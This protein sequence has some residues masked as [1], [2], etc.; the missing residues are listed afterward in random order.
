M[1]ILLDL[2]ACQASSMHR[3]IG[4]YSMALALAMARNS[5]GHE[6]R[7]L[8]NEDYP[9]SVA[10]IRTA[11]D[12]LVP[13]SQIGSFLTPVPA[14]EVDPR[15][16]WRVH[17][18]ERVRLHHLASLRPDVVHV[19][20]LFEGLGDNVVASVPAAD[21]GYDTAVTLYD[22]IPLMRKERYLVDPNMSA[23]Y[24]RK[25]ESMKRAELL[26]AISASA[27]QEGIDLLQLPIERVVNISS[28]VDA[29]FRPRT[30]APQARA[31]L[32][33]GFGLKRDFIMY[34]GGIDYR[35]NIEGLI[36]AYA[37][38][39]GQLRRQYQ[40]AV[41]CSIRDPDRFRLERLAAKFNLTKDDLVLT[42]FVSDDDLVS[43]YNCTSLFVFPSL[44][45]GFGLPALEAMA[46]GAPVIG[47]NTSSIP[48][49]IGRADAM[50]D[51]ASVEAIAGAMAQVLRDPAR[52]AALRAHGLAQAARFSWD[53]SAQRAIGAFEEVHRRRAAASSVN[54][55]AGAPARKPR[56]AYVSPLPPTRSGIAAYSAD[57]LPE[58]AQHYEIDLVLAQDGVDDPA[59][60]HFPQRSSAWFD[61]NAHRF[62]HIVYQ[63]GNSAFH[64]HMFGLLERHPGVVVLHDFFL[65][66]VINHAEVDHELPNH[67]CRSL[68]L[69]H[70]YG[71]LAEEKAAGRTASIMTYPCNRTVLDRATGVIVHSAHAVALANRWYGPGYAADWRVL[72]L[73]CLRPGTDET[74][75]AARAELGIA[76]DDFVVCSFGIL[77][78]PKCNDRLVE[79][80]IDS[81]LARDPRCRL[82]FVGEVAQGRFGIALRDR[83]AAH[84]RI[85]V[86]GY[87]ST[88][89]YRRY[90]TAAD[91]AVQLRGSSRG[92]T[93]GA[94]FDCLSYGLPTVVNAHGSAAE[95][96]PQVCL[97]LEDAFSQDELRAALERL[98]GDAALRARLGGAAAAYM[99]ETHAPAR[100]AALYREALEH[101]A[102]SS[103][104]AAEQRL[105]RSIAGL[106]AEVPD[107]DLL[108][109]AAAIAANRP[110][111]GMRQVLVDIGAL[112]DDTSLLTQPPAGWR[113]EPIRYDGTRWR[114]ARRGTLDLIGRLDL[115]IEDGVVDAKCGDVLLAPVGDAAP[116]LPPTWKA[117]G[118]QAVQLASGPDAI[119]ASLAALPAHPGSAAG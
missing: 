108:Q 118:V 78:A 28:A 41:V 110:R 9:D 35:K 86:T 64:S 16:A 44:H 15:N 17:A 77:S 53:A 31:A 65:S 62:H 114:Y 112:G 84:P 79:A 10:A 60:A 87:A 32:L 94:V 85:T 29:I 88:A 42:G 95:V 26:L 101:V 74:R 8:L 57:L 58:L 56:L 72:P 20:S 47:S 33:A 55:A 51:P 113:L 91:A 107:P 92:E 80:W 89:L 68:Y 69:A 3:G 119:G 27:R 97:R 83:I 37:R 90:L 70:G 100:A 43:L 46:C 67:Y 22:L 76:D 61:E 34:T 4:R 54:V 59:L 40:L 106:G 98:Y 7:I 81:T 45:E 105:I 93:S 1:R 38:L 30:L 21:A 102:L 116:V 12:G 23:W 104:G 11:F 73:V 115:Q 71:A 18:A 117:R 25:L 14:G 19:A 103:Q 49:V 82:V 75:A 52:Q 24:Y 36:E 96:P 2:Q 99:E 13:Q 66:G 6:L 111:K 48:E 63:F 39:P 5:G 50:F 109:T